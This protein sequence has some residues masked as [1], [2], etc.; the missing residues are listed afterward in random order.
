MKCSKRSPGISKAPEPYGGLSNEMGNGYNAASAA[1]STFDSA[2]SGSLSK[3][4]KRSLNEFKEEGLV[5]KTVSVTVEGVSH[6]LV[7]Y[8][9]VADVMNNKFI[10]PTKDPKFQHVTPQPDLITKQNFRTPIDE[11]PLT[12]P[13]T[14]NLF[15]NHS[16]APNFVCSDGTNN[17][18][19]SQFAPALGIYSVP[20]SENYDIW[21]D[22]VDG[23]RAAGT[24][25]RA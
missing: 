24:R 22:T 11:T 15:N 10:T 20:K 12:Y 13:Q 25:S 19:G 2:N 17:A 5:K 21:E 6:H 3:E 23:M 16:V 9:T 14:S 1:A 4:T 7:S 8:Y 18:D